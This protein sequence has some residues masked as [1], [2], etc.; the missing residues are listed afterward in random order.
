MLT[1]RAH[2]S[3]LC[4]G[5]TRREAM[6]IGGLGALGAGLGLADLTRA[7]EFSA[8]RAKSCIVLFLMGGPPQHSTWDPK[9]DTPPEVRG[10]YG[11]IATSMGGANTSPSR[12]PKRKYPRAHS[13]P[14]AAISGN[15]WLRPECSKR[16]W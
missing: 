15:A 7:G 13:A 16:W 3:R 14:C 6:R 9:P 5:I 8:G 11:P 10:A 2:G 12:A 4:D 1:L